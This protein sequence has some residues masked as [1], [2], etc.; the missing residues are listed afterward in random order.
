[1]VLYWCNRGLHRTLSSQRLSGPLTAP[2]EHYGTI[3][4]RFTSL[5]SEESSVQLAKTQ[6]TLD[7][8]K[9]HLLGL[10]LMRTWDLCRAA[11]TSNP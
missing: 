11:S 4:Y 5:T 6:R 2:L 7:G 10:I 9:S 1:M 3:E 8:H